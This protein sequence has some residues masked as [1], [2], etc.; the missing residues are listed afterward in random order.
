MQ[1]LY[2]ALF[3]LLAAIVFSV[4][5]MVPRARGWAIPIPTGILGAGAFAL[6]GF[7][8]V[9]FWINHP[10]P[11]PMTRNFLVPFFT[12]G[13]L[14]GLLGGA[15]TWVVARWVASIL[16][17]ILLR[18]TVFAAGWCSYFVVLAALL[19]WGDYRFQLKDTYLGFGIEVLL[20][21]IAAW[22]ISTRSGE[23]RPRR[24]VAPS[25]PGVEALTER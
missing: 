5:S 15:L 14:T 20:A 9:A 17:A 16:S 7:G 13:A 2:E 1:I 22:F 8:A 21:F 10:G 25:L 24:R 12:A 3:L 11:R 6:V 23:F 4:L 18:V 19:L